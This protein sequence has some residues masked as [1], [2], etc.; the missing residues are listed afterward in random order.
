VHQRVDVHEF[1]SAEL[2]PPRPPRTVPKAI[3][4]AKTS[5]GARV[6]RAEHAILRIASC[7]RAGVHRPRGQR[8]ASAC[9]VR[10]RQLQQ[11]GEGRAPRRL[12]GVICR[13]SICGIHTCPKTSGSDGLAAVGLP[14]GALDGID[15]HGR[16]RAG[17]HAIAVENRQLGRMGPVT[18]GPRR[19]VNSALIG[20][21]EG[22]GPPAV[23]S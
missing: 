23:P 16:H 17:T 15:R 20:V 10:T 6:C 18:R 11:P 22:V 21:G 13:M 7:N 8:A 19:E 12:I 9:S 2:P 4:V 3:R 1:D 5:A 14:D